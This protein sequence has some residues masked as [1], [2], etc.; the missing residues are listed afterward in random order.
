MASATGVKGL[1]QISR[2]SVSTKERSVNTL[3]LCDSACSHSWIS[4]DLSKKLG[5]NGKPLRLTVSG[6]NTQEI[7]DTTQVKIRIA[8]CDKENDFALETAPFVKNDINVGT[9]TIDVNQLQREY[10]HLAPRWA[11]RC[12]ASFDKF[13]LERNIFLQRD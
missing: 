10:P 2:L 1:L 11:P 9:D 4:A 3:A 8:S 5:L 13:V 12:F 6:I 7:I